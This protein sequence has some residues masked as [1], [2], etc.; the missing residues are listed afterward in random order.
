MKTISIQSD[1]GGVGKTSLAMLLANYC[2]S[3]LGESVCLVDLDFIG[4][5][6]DSLGFSDHPAVTIDDFLIQRGRR[7]PKGMVSEV[8]DLGD[9]TKLYVV[10]SR[11]SEDSL[12]LIADE[13]TYGQIRIRLTELKAYLEKIGV[14]NLIFDC[15]TG[16]LMEK[17][18]VVLSDHCVK[19]LGDSV[20]N[21]NAVIGVIEFLN[22]GETE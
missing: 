22:T 18:M 5:G 2:L 16:K 15:S 7:V 13:P 4:I 10:F 20:P 8:L 11:R 12:G 6:F 1:K 14:E 19:L 3:I 21:T 9:E 17:T